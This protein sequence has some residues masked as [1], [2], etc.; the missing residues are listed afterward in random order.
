MIK[1]LIQLFFLLTI[2]NIIAQEKNLY[3]IYKQYYDINSPKQQNAYLYANDKIAIYEVDMLNNMEWSKS[4]DEQTIENGSRIIKAD[5]RDNYFFKTIVNR[6]EVL[7]FDY[8]EKGK[9]VLITDKVEQNWLITD[10]KKMINDIECYKAITKYRGIEWTAWFAPSIPYP[11]GPWKLH[12]LPGLIMEAHDN[13]KKYNYSVQQ[14]EFKKQDIL[15]KD[16]KSLA[17]EKI[18]KEMTMKEFVN[19]RDEGREV[20]MNDIRSRGMTVTSMH[21]GKARSGR[22]LV[23]E[24]D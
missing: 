3:A 7:F 12:G 24:W 6:N 14:L 17:S 4:K 23:Y 8:L 9:R 15:K 5:I 19:A 13:N 10:E 2:T 20:L 22:E 16:F 1:N 21:K 11:Y 18:F